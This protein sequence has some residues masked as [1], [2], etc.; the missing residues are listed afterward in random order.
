M[1]RKSISFLRPAP[2]FN[3]CSLAIAS[4]RHCCRADLKSPGRLS[5]ASWRLWVLVAMVCQ[6]EYFEE[7]A[8]LR[9][10]VPESPCELVDG[11]HVH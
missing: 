10:S 1:P 6:C 8:M 4:G 11:R 9:T 5:V 2:E 7:P 3:C